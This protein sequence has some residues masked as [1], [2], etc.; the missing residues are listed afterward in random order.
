MTRPDEHPEPATDVEAAFAEGY[1]R[2]VLRGCPDVEAAL[3]YIAEQLG[4]DFEEILAGVDEYDDREPFDV[5]AAVRRINRALQ[6]R[7]VVVRGAS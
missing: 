4:F 7:D 3:R 5:T 6:E 2:G 1:A